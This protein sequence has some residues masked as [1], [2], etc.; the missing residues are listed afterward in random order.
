[1]NLWGKLQYNQTRNRILI[2]I[3]WICEENSFLTNEE[4]GMRFY[5]QYSELYSNF[6]MNFNEIKD[7]I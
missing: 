3:L 4:V 1:M 2:L 5:A 7:L 6:L